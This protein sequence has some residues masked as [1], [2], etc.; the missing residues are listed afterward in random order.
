MTMLEVDIAIIG[1]GPSGL[2]ASYYAGFR[3]LRTALID[4][5][6]EVG[7]QIA[8]LYPEKAI[9]DVAGFPSIRGQD[10]VDG[11]HAQATRWSP[12]ILLECQAVGLEE[13]PEHVTITM[14]DGRQV[15]AA[16]L[17]ITAGIGTFEPRQL[18]DGLRLEDRGLRYFV[19]RLN[20]LTAQDVVIVGGGDSAVD[21]ALALED[22]AASVTLVH[23]RPAFRAHERSVEQLMDSTVTVLT[24]YEVD[25]PSETSTSP[26]SW[27]AARTAT[28]STFRHARSS[29]RWASSPTSAR[30]SSGDSSAPPSHR[31]RSHAAH[32]PR[33]GLRRWRRHAL[34]RQGQAHLD[35]LRR[36]GAGGQPHCAV[37]R[38]VLGP[39][40]RALHGRLRSHRRPRS[41]IERGL[42]RGLGVRAGSRPSAA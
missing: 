1:A 18:A 41:S 8:A 6:P 29:P 11:L 23:R 4:S 13:T 39:Q 32:Q 34:R 3:G 15:R 20:D 24:P 31:R 21:W 33:A 42:R 17:L 19:P 25:E 37:D 7:G 10:L 26:P 2:Y 38:S 5:L 27:S 14:S 36:G 30:W 40:P 16:A 12:E 22:V 9:F 35:R 28:S